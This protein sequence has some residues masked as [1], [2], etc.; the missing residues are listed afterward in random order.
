MN[1][2]ISIIIPLYNS[3]KTI[4]R[5][6]D[7]ILCQ[8]FSD[9]EVIIV[10][11]GSTDDGV[12]FVKKNYND[13]RIKIISQGNRGVSAAR[14]HGAREAKGEFLVFQDADDLW[15]KFH[16]ADLVDLY[17]RYPNA[18]IYSTA[19]R[20]L[21]ATFSAS[22]TV[23][24]NNS[25]GFFLIDYFRYAKDYT[26]FIHGSTV[27]FKKNIFDRVG[28]FDETIPVGEDLDLWARILFTRDLAFCNKISSFYVKTNANSASSNSKIRNVHVTVLETIYN[29][30]RNSDIPD[31]KYKNV[32]EFGKAVFL[33]KLNGL[34]ARGYRDFPYFYEVNYGD[35]FA[36]EYKK[37]LHNKL[38]FRLFLIKRFLKKILH[39]PH[40]RKYVFRRMDMGNVVKVFSKA[41]NMSIDF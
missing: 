21:Y 16:L 20:D 30:K 17:N 37:I 35:F 23:K 11:D 15:T 14:N 26:I 25:E 8:T 32:I 31:E 6:L 19:H 34:I 28:G 7:S 38:F 12:P 2:K 5:T 13:S 22:Y 4:G 29:L 41:N 33:M 39:T 1:P 10:N 9:F 36:P 18:G 27:L 3:A 24:S 40:I